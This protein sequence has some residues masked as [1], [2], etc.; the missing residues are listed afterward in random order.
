MD[1]KGLKN[2]FTGILFEGKAT[3]LILKLFDSSTSGSILK[4]GTGHIFI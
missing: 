4:G 1:N 2:W 3:F